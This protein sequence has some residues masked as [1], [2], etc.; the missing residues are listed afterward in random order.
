MVGGKRRTQCGKKADLQ[1]NGNPNPDPVSVQ[2]TRFG[3]RVSLFGKVFNPAPGS[4]REKGGLEHGK[5]SSGRWVGRGAPSVERS[6]PTA[7]RKTRTQTPGFGARNGVW[8]VSK[9]V[10]EGLESSPRISTL[11][12]GSG[13][14]FFG[15]RRWKGREASTVE[16]SGPTAKRKPESRHPVSAQETGFGT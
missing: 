10:R 6:G 9:P 5:V 7:K 12:K 16:R 2:E 11:K 15:T 8:N 1:P 3:T 13:T 14:C 4:Q